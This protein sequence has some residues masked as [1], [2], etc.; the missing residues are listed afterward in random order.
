[1]HCV[2]LADLAATLSQHGPAILYRCD[3]VPSE[4]ITRYWTSSR[5]RVDLW[6]QAMARYKLADQY[7]N[8]SDLRAW[9]SD[10]LVVL[11]EILVSEI[12]TR[13]ISAIAVGMEDAKDSDEISPI[14]HAIY[15]THLE[16]RNR[17][18]ELMLYGRGISVS[19]AVRLNRLRQGVERWTDTLIGRM[20]AM[21]PQMIRYAIDPKRAS[22]HASEMRQCSSR[23]S[24]MTSNWLLNASMHDTISRRTSKATA[25]PQANHGVANSV[26]LMLRPDLFD[27][28]G[29]LKSIWLHRLQ[30]DS[31]RADRVL[32]GLGEKDNAPTSRTADGFDA[33]RD[34]NFERWYL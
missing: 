7:A 17:V 24:L 34:P 19:E 18:Q 2:L 27:S 25:L 32:H 5:T 21:K 13:V 4:A 16:A 14:T 31:E 1:M 12:L 20:A 9:W 6:H 23:R 30:I 29:A 22:E 10:H 15:L 28:V 3:T 26:L 8:S 11:E 33:V